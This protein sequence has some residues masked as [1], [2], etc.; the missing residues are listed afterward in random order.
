MWPYII[1]NCFIVFYFD[2]AFQMDEA[3]LKE[4]TLI[5][6]FPGLESTTVFDGV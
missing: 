1:N 5:N 3:N 6:E 4:E 2:Q